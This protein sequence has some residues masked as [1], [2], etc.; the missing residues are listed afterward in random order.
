[1]II[2]APKIETQ[3]EN[4]MLHDVHTKPN[5]MGCHQVLANRLFQ[6]ADDTDR[7]GLHREATAL[8]LFAAS[9]LDGRKFDV[10]DA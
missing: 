2:K 1:M 4:P 3:T 6:L 10:C 9:V 5:S 8:A 7:V